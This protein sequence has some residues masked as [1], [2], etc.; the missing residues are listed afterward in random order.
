MA[1]INPFLSKPSEWVEEM[2]N[3]RD[4]RRKL[5]ERTRH[6]EQKL[7]L[8]M[9]EKGI[10]RFSGD[11]HGVVLTLKDGVEALVLGT[12]SVATKA[13]DEIVNHFTKE[14]K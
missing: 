6:L 10:T 4:Q 13:E 11:K 2:A 12:L 3:I 7:M 14:G 5:D 8:H 1:N 9:K